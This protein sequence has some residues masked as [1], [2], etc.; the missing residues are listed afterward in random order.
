MRSAVD[1][2]ESFGVRW[3]DTTTH[4]RHTTEPREEALPA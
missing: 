1:V 4:S 3:S 2:A